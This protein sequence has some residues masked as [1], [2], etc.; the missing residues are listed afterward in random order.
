VRPSIEKSNRTNAAE[1]LRPSATTCRRAC[2]CQPTKVARSNA[3]K[4]LAKDRVSAAIAARL[5]QRIERLSI[6]GGDEALEHITV[7]ARADIGKVLDPEDRWRSSPT[8]CGPPSQPSGRTY[9]RIIELHDSMRAAELLAK[10]AGRLPKRHDHRVRVGLL[11]LLAPETDE[12]IAE[13][14]GR[15]CCRRRGALRR[16]GLRTPH[17]RPTA[18]RPRGRPPL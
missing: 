12:Q 10:A 3:C 18:A 14:S 11:D 4:L 1:F 2:P 15:G 7:I 17:A 9:G 13:V 6:M 8:M 16:R 5:A